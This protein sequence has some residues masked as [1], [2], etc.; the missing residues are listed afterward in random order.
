MLIVEAR[1]R[2]R[3]AISIHRLSEITEIKLRIYALAGIGIP[4]DLCARREF[5]RTGSGFTEE[6]EEEEEV[7]LPSLDP[8]CGREASRTFPARLSLHV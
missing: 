1:M 5:F 6:E 8:S 4:G 2:S 3:D 7:N